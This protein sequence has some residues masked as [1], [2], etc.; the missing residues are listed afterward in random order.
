[1]LRRLGC[2]LFCALVVLLLG[3]LLFLKERTPAGS[4]EAHQHFLAPPRPHHSQCS[5]NLTVV[6]TSLSLPSRHRLF[7]TYR[8]CRNFS[9][10][11][12]P[13]ECARDIFLLLVIKSQPAH[14]EQRAAIR[15]TW[16]RGGSWARGRQLKLVFLLGVAGPVPPAQLLAYESWQFD[17]ILQWDFAED[18]FNLTLKELHVQ[19][20]IAAACTQAHFILK[21]DD[22]VFIHVPNV[23]E[24]LEGWDPAQDLLVGD[25]I[26]LARPNR[27]TKVKYFIP[28]S[29]YRARHYPPYAFICKL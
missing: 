26:R 14:I 15:S 2:V 16:G 24:F 22:D 25:V 28:F 7:L 18:F 23:L 9:I 11:L 12:E 21:G 19:R 17:D 29:M 5:P 1:M 27:N 6:N 8:H 13:S 10:L 3:C 4:S 20:W